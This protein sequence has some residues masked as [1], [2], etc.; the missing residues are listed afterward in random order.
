MRASNTETSSVPAAVGRPC[1]P[2]RDVFEAMT[3][4]SSEDDHGMEL[5]AYHTGPAPMGRPQ[6]DLLSPRDA[7]DSK[8]R[9][10]DEDVAKMCVA[11]PVR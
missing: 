5:A 6:S 2:L 10:V 9:N 4:P 11:F 3:W 8:P 1:L 7:W